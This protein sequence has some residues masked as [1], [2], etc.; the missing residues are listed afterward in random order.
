MKIIWVWVNCNNTKEAKK[1]G[2]EVLKQR[3]ISCYDLLPRLAAYYFWPPKSG[4][5]EK[6]EGC[7]LIMETLPKYFSKIE[8][9]M[10]KLHS[11][12]LPFIGSL[13]I[14]NI[15]QEYA[16]WIKGELK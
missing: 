4:K 6:A 12:N 3:L 2:D 16:G 9:V 7:F 11:D 10:R 14:N 13:E 15:S 5:I 8:R 1:I